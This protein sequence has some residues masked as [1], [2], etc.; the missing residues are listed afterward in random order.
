MI[1][2]DLGSNTIRF[3]EFDGEKWGKSF[4]KIVRTAEG[5]DRTRRIG[6]NALDRILEAI[7]E[8]KG[9]LDF[10]DQTVVGYTTAAMRMASNASEVL[11]TIRTKSGIAFEVI[12]PHKE[13]ELTLRAVRYRLQ[14]LG[15]KPESFVLADIGGGSTELIRYERGRYETVSL[16]IGIVTLSER[17][18]SP[19]HLKEQI[20]QFKKEVRNGVR[21]EIGTLVMSA[22]TPTTIAA[23]RMGMEYES[24]DPHKI[25][26]YRL[27]LEECDRVYDE[28]LTME[29]QERIRYVGVGRENLVI[30][31]ILMVRGIYEA[32]ERNEAVVIDDGL[33][34]GI[35]L[36]Y[37]SRD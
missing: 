28:L 5:L 37:Y 11:D 18:H 35:A 1:A 30:A 27:R 26:G 15:M 14:K 10:S 31:G 16:N 20:E 17:S 32:F 13:G 33:R 7:D 19:D 4:E 29:E 2:I 6:E 12:D 36:E 9:C 25:N 23:Y 3:I 22:G 21:G 34:E 24:Y 8:A